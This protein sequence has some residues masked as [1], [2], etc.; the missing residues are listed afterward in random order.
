MA[1]V[2]VLVN[3]ITPTSIP[4]ELAIRTTESTQV[5]VTVVSLYGKKDSVGFEDSL[6]LRFLEAESRT[7]FRAWRGFRREL[8]QGYDLLHTHHNF[9]GSVARVLA[10]IQGV[11]VVNTEHRDHSSF[12]PLQNIVN[13]PTLPLADVLVTN[14]K[15]TK[16]SF[17]WYENILVD[18]DRVRVIYNGVNIDRVMDAVQSADRSRDT[19]YRICTVG[20][21]VPVKNQETLL[22]AFS[23]VVDRKPNSELVIVGDGPLRQK[24]ESKSSTLGISNKTRFTGEVSRNRVYEILASSDVFVVPSHA[25]GF[26]VA[27]VEA[28]AAGLPVVASDIE[29]LREVVGDPGVFADPTDASGFAEPINSLLDDDDERE[30]IGN[31]SREKARNSFSLD[32]T[33]HQ[34]CNIYKELADN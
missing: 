17:R 8:R 12:S 27:A 5:D 11:P 25:E 28:M 2:L 21:L 29:V 1:R 15:V 20:R 32:E 14:S 34:Y 4:F 18:T 23:S 31:E 22:D 24:L 13:A 3:K 19:P 10:K 33:V 6:D 7:D 30:N 16:N 26:C 9:S